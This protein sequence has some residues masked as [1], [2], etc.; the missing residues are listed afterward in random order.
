MS[1][2]P[3]TVQDQENLSCIQIQQ[4]LIYNPMPSREY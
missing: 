3:V 2:R 4:V 1:I